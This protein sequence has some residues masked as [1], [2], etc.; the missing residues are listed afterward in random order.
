[1][2]QALAAVRWAAATLLVVACAGA[3]RSLERTRNTPPRDGDGDGLVDP[4]DACW[5]EA[6]DLDGFADADGCPD[7]DDDA[8]G[9][10]DRCDACPREAASELGDGCPVGEAPS[11]P[12]QILDVIPF[13]AGD[14]GLPDDASELLDEL[15]RALA[16]RADIRTLVVL[17]HGDVGE[18]DV[19]ALSERRASVVRDA[20]V[21]R[22]VEPRRLRAEGHGSDWPLAR[23][24]DHR[25]ERNRRVSFFVERELAPPPWPA[26]L[27]DC[28]R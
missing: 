17:G 18:P 5:R 10:P 23:P 9:V 16:E 24:S 28:P 14:A 7:V 22:G 6:E 20:L 2:A 13:E 26:R 21:A 1:M 15:A 11:P 8:D 19:V 4:L 12:P 27:A 25:P 3:P